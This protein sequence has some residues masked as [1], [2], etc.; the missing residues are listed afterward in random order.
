MRKNTCVKVAS[1]IIFILC[2]VSQAETN[3]N[4]WSDA[5]HISSGD[6]PDFDIHQ[7]TGNLHLIS[8]RFRF[9]RALSHDLTFRD[10]QLL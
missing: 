2:T 9:G 3:E 8:I 1:L 6:T 5:I 4:S 10:Q 7:A